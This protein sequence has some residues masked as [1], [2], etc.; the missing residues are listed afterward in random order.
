MIYFISM[1]EM[2]GAGD[3]LMVAQGGE[4]DKSL[5]RFGI[6]KCVYEVCVSLCV[7]VRERKGV[8]ASQDKMCVSVCCCPDS[9]HG[10]E[11]F[12]VDKGPG[13]EVVV[14]SSES[15]CCVGLC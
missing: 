7:C 10:S 9:L 11:M 13:D 1:C 14:P 15:S 5:M 6:W 8:V 4:W 3:P 2:R 12:G